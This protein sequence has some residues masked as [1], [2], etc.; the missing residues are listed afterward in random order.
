MVAVEGIEI[1]SW[2]TNEQTDGLARVPSERADG[3]SRTG[4]QTDA[5][6][7]MYVSRLI[8]SFV[9]SLVRRAAASVDIFLFFLYYNTSWW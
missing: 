9:R 6:C 4:R 3:S 8:W 2:P 1:K 7:G 5:Q